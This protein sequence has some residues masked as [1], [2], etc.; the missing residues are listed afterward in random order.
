[1]SR[2]DLVYREISAIYSE[3]RRFFVQTIFYRHFVKADLFYEIVFFETYGMKF[4]EIPHV[5]A[6]NY[7]IR[8]IQT[9]AHRCDNVRKVFLT[10]A[11]IHFR[12]PY[13]IS[14]SFQTG[15]LD[16]CNSLYD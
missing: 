5:I 7:G 1:M 6:K 16:T 9:V 12:F 8:Q 4:V 13:R 10:L 2:V 15:G 14:N 3:F 11:G